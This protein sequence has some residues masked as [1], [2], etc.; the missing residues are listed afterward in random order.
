MIIW[1][2]WLLQTHRS[3]HAEGA[4]LNGGGE[5]A[6]GKQLPG[7]G[8]WMPSGVKTV[9]RENLYSEEEAPARR[10]EG[11]EDP[12]LQRSGPSSARLDRL[13]IGPT[14]PCAALKEPSL[15]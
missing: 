3:A 15:R 5:A 6:K 1:T 7:S 10:S 8:G 13:C 4:E 2:C 11:P 12:R 14:E 9:Q